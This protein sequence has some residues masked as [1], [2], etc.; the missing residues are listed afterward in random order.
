MLVLRLNWVIILFATLVVRN[1]PA[2]RYNIVDLGTLGGGSYSEAFAINEKTEVAA[3]AH[4]DNVA[5]GWDVNAA[6]FTSLGALKDLGT[7]GGRQGY[8]R[9]INDVGYAAG[10]SY[11]DTAQVLGFFYNG[12]SMVSVGTLGGTRSEAYGINNVGQVVGVSTLPSES[13]NFGYRRAFVWQ[14]G[15]GMTSLDTLG[16]RY[17]AALAIN[18]A[19]AITIVGHSETATNGPTHAFAWTAAG[20]MKDLGSLGGADKESIAYGVNDFAAVVGGTDGAGV[21]SAERAFIWDDTN[22]LRGLGT[23]PNSDSTVAYGINNLGVI[24]GQAITQA[25]VQ[26]YRTMQKRAFVYANGTMEDLQDLIPSTSGWRLQAAYSIN[27]AG[28]IVGVGLNV[29][30]D[31]HGFLLVAGDTIAPQPPGGFFVN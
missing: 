19:A 23:L 17:S 30:G 11:T 8:A 1:A 12:S 16:G 3:A 29:D 4:I 14:Q 31:T 2:A 22:G 7:L 5:G 26:P 9:A 15:V 10:Y 20:G 21:S 25:T 18:D 13:P 24:V 6:I 27:E 28:E